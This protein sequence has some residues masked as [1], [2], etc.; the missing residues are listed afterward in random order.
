[1]AKI[2]VVCNIAPHIE[3]EHPQAVLEAATHR[4]SIDNQ[5]RLEVVCFSLLFSC[6][7]SRQLKH[8]L[9]AADSLL[10]SR[11]R[12]N[13]SYEMRCETFGFS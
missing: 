1:M 6:L 9:H 3:G 12:G 2:K 5:V 4:D 10:D 8:T 7:V 11:L 13:D